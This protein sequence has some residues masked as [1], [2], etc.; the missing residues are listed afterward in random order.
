M[1]LE[2]QIKKILENFDDVPSDDFLDV[3]NQIQN[4][5]QSSITQEYLSG[6]LKT[7]SQTPSEAEKKKLCKN[8]LP[9]L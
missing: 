7:I 9:S 1:S 3:L 2:I 5:F 4:K 6:K 8:L